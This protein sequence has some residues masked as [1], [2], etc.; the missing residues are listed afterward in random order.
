MTYN[1]LRMRD[2]STHIHPQTNLALHET[3]GP[4]IMMRGEGAYV[5]DDDGKQ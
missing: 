2:I 5:Y 3:L 1:S 4:T